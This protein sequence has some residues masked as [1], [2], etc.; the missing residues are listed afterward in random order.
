M[1]RK[2]FGRFGPSGTAARPLL[3]LLAIGKHPRTGN[4]GATK[5]A[6]SGERLLTEAEAA[7]EL[8]ISVAELREM[9]R[10]QRAPEH[11]HITVATIRYLHS[12]VQ[13]HRKR[14]LQQ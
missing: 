5:M 14:G 3:L 9:A 1:Q 11:F 7:A 12:A 2:S 8:E 10:E 4:E 13:T 6:T